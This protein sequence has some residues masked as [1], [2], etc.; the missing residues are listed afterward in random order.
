MLRL[1]P[2]LI[3]LI[4]LNAHSSYASGTEVVLQYFAFA[5]TDTSKS[6]LQPFPKEYF[7]KL[8]ECEVRLFELYRLQQNETINTDLDLGIDHHGQPRLFVERNDKIVL[9]WYCQLQRVRN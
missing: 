8:A 6:F 5:K 2:S 9:G 1:L 4:M 3:M 7:E